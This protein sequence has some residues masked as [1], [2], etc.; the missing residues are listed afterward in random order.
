M[1]HAVVSLA[2]DREVMRLRLSFLYIAESLP[3]APEQAGAVD[4]S[5]Q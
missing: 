4:E 5:H 3:S 1:G 2:E